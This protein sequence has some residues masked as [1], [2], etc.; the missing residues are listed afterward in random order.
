MVRG[1]TFPEEATSGMHWSFGA[2]LFPDCMT[3]LFMSGIVKGRVG[4]L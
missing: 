3:F 2:R 1:W 4:L